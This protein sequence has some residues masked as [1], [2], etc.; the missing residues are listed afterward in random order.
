MRNMLPGVDKRTAIEDIEFDKVAVTRART[1]R[2]VSWPLVP[3]GVWLAA[4]GLQRGE[5]T[6]RHVRVRNA[7][8]RNPA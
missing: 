1:R 7:T 4:S 3:Q 6:C 2:G 8:A 5:R